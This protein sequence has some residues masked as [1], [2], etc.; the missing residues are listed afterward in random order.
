MPA[1]KKLTKRLVDSTAPGPSDVFLWDSEL[2]GFG[3]KVAPSGRRVYVF[4]YARG[5][6]RPRMTIGPHGAPWTPDTAR[7]E[8]LR[9]RGEVARGGD[10]AS[11]K[12]EAKGAPTMKDFADRYLREHAEP[13]KK[14]AS[15]RNDKLLLRLHVLP[16]LGR[17]KV[18][19][20]TRAD[21]T[22][23]HLA[24]KET[25]M[26]ANRA[27]ALLSKM[28]NLAERWGIRPEH[29][30]PCRHVEKYRELRRTRFLSETELAALGKVLA[31]TER[32]KSEPW[33]ATAAI[34]LLLF[35]GRR[36]SEVLSLRWADV[37][38]ERAV[39][40]LPDSKTGAKSFALAPPALE[41]LKALPRIEDN[42]HVLPGRT[43]K[44]KPFVGLPHVWHRLREKA[45]LDGVRIHDLRHAFASAGASSG[46]AL[47]LIGA[48]L[49]H[50]TP[51][52][53]ARYA[54]LSDNPV[55]AAGDRIAA[56]MAAALSGKRGK[57]V[58]IRQGAGA[59]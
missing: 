33:Q 57:V 5:S 21:V 46:E 49:G 42:P 56:I 9:L 44:G 6:R 53:T 22:R 32:A 51:T 47:T 17:L 30:N 12:S 38:F 15:V 59:R 37:D 23:L 50:T 18:A 40:T 54:H 43:R 34:R 2:P 58:S 31:K 10:P 1:G 28:F 39:L 45:G 19:D 36:V 8:A 25:P 26:Q 13:K 11:V 16:T 35:T 4:Q 55:R 7:K 41:V 48:L 3:L 29:S 14:A 24:M 27:L 52:M 20:V